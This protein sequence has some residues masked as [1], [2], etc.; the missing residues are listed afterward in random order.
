MQLPAATASKAEK[1][2][3]DFN[4]EVERLRGDA[5]LTAAARQRHIAVAYTQAVEQM[6]ALRDQWNGGRSADEV[7]LT[8]QCFGS[9]TASGSD[10]ISVR[11]AQDRAQQI[12]TP[13][14]ALGLLQLAAVNNDESLVRAIAQGAYTEVTSG[15]FGRDLGWGEPLTYFA[16]QRPRLVDKINALTSLQR[17]DVFAVEANF[18]IP[19]PTELGSLND[20]AIA[21]LAVSSEPP[22][23]AAQPDPSKPDMSAVTF[24]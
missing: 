24:P 16:S 10:A 8:R 3:Q 21:A 6:S 15:L 4:R 11:D 2:A 23:P 13:S 7:A 17:V 14:E 19:K 18:I 1:T 20:Y 5:D 12:E 9:S 22:A